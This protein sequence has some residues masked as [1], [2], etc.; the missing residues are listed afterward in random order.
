[1]KKIFL[2]QLFLFSAISFYHSQ[3]YFIE[4]KGQIYNENNVERQDVIAT[5]QSSKGLFIIR[6]DGY[7]F[8]EIEVL[9]QKSAFNSK[10]DLGLENKEKQNNYRINR[11]DIS[12]KKANQKIEIQKNQKVNTNFNFYNTLNGV[13][14]LNVSAF[15]EILLK[16]IYSGIDVRFY[17]KNNELEYDYIVHETGNLNQI[18]LQITGGKASL[19]NNG[20]LKIYSNLGN[21]IESA[22]KVLQNR[23][24]IKSE[25]EL[26][27]TQNVCF[28]IKKTKS[29]SDLIID[30]IIR[31]WGTYLG[32]TGIEK[33]NSNDIETDSEGNVFLV[34]STNS[35]SNIV[36]SFAYSTELRGDFDAVL[37]KFSDGGELI[38]STYYGGN[39]IDDFS[40]IAINSTNQIICGGFTNSSQY[41]TTMGV[42]EPDLVGNSAALLVKFSEHGNRI[43]GTYF[44]G[45][46]N[47]LGLDI[48]DMGNI[49]LV[50]Q[51]FTNN[52]STNFAFQESINGNSEYLLAKLDNS[53]NRIWATYYGGSQ[54]ENGIGIS[55]LFDSQGNIFLIG[56][57]E[58]SSSISSSGAHQE[59]I[60]GINDGFVAKF[61]SNGNRL[62]A[63][64]LGG[65]SHEYIYGAYVD[66]D[67]NAFI[68]GESLS[69]NF[70]TTANA[71]QTE[72]RGGLDGIIGK[73]SP[74][75][76]L[77]WSTFYGDTLHEEI[78]DL[79]IDTKG[80]IWFSGYTNSP[81]MSSNDAFQ[82]VANGSNDLFIAKFSNDGNRIWAS[83]YGGEDQEAKGKIALGQNGDVFLSGTTRSTQ[84]I[85]TNNSHQENL[86]GMDDYFIVKFNDSD[87][88]LGLETLNS[89]TNEILF[90][91]PTNSFFQ[92]NDVNDQ[93]LISVKIM[94]SQGKKVF[95]S[96]KS[97]SN[98][99]YDVSDLPAG[100][101]LVKLQFQDKI[102]FQKIMKN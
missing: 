94:D 73:F 5:F 23:K 95:S 13:P 12:W 77:L 75:G 29:K 17:F 86:S 87:W 92:I 62:W 99:K 15:N 93:K 8:Q 35:V 28:K 60:G 33:T 39:G 42:Y 81:N 65:S 102:I 53:G 78:H 45:L 37:S 68:L 7:S 97:A 98:F 16:N 90:P 83:Y 40:K 3:S 41:V 34:G 79:A 72:N 24:I 20:D 100:V 9:N 19:E 11:L 38:W 69:T 61:D 43:W 84:N 46:I 52:L 59:Q 32:G 66:N 10:N 70:P 48:D 57:T 18:Q 96:T 88:N 31:E 63:S 36:T 50:S 71:W 30:P 89:I 6:K 49:C 27:D 64:Y 14:I 54:A 4:N 76:N 21:I 67:G 85:S 26:N 91:N 80:N 47:N 1:M 2:I 74:N 82:Q 58:S 55:S 51:T 56:E 22:P 25:W 44:S 101:Y